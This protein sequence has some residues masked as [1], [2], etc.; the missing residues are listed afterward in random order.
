MSSLED[1]YRFWSNKI[2]D[3]SR[4]RLETIKS[5]AGKW[6]AT[7]A[8]FLGVYA[9]VGFILSPDKL[10]TLPVHGT[11]EIILFIGY[12]L[13]GALGITAVIILAAISAQR[14]KIDIDKPLTGLTY[15]E[16]VMG[17]A[18]TASHRFR[19][20]IAF[21]AVAG[22]VSITGSGYLL[23]AGVV[24]TNHP[25]ATLVSPTGAY[26]GELLNS[27]GKLSLR[28]QTGEII[29]VTGGSLTPVNSCPD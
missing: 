3:D 29:S 1:E 19:L 28:L 9:T 12:G 26:C 4:N 11:A 21:A 25:H 24:A 2:A 22:F 14:P 8:A 17:Q 13:A 5:S 10:A 20:A 27:N 18:V 23:I 6:Q 15:H 7:L 16:I